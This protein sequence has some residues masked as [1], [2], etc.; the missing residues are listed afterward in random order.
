MAIEQLVKKALN[1]VDFKSCCSGNGSGYG[2]GF[3]IKSNVT[4][5]K[6]GKKVHI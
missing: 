4:C 5:H 6:C 1:P 2:R 3:S